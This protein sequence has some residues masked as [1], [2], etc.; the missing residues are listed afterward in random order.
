MFRAATLRKEVPMQS[1]RPLLGQLCFHRIVTRRLKAGIV[2][3]EE[4]F[5]SRQR[6]G[7]Q[8]SAA[9]DTKAAIE[10]FWGTKFPVWSM[11]S[12]NKRRELVNLGLVGS[13]AVK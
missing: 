13:R 12:G 3:P 6:L 8:V 10:K 4:T 7:K 5:I 11:R 9:T 1:L 2:E